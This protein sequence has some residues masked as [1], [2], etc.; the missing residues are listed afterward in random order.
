M[1]E[2]VKKYYNDI[3]VHELNRLNNHYSII[4]Y[5]STMYLIDKYMKK[6]T[7]I[8]DIGSGPGR[9][10]V[11]LLKKQYKISL[12]DISDKS[13]DLAKQ[14]I[15][16]ENYKAENYYAMS[17]LELDKFEDDTFDN[18][19][20]LGPMYHLH[21]KLDRL[22][23]LK[24]AK[25]IVKKDGIIIISYINSYGIIRSS[26]F[27]FPEAYTDDK[28][29][30]QSLKGDLQLSSEESFTEAY[31]TKPLLAG[32]EIEEAG[33]KILS[34]AG[35]ESFLSGLHLEL[36]RLYDE[37]DQTIYNNYIRIAS[38][39]CEM[40]HYK[41]TTEHTLFVCKVCKWCVKFLLI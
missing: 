25:R 14:I 5:K 27:E 24:N 35:A 39:N 15:E 6:N 7:H 9:Y 37:E 8:F 22:E 28:S 23:V 21:S 29:F 19:L 2:I 3:S 1:S 31:F 41:D 17:A 32:K 38:E 40:E 13:I 26:L 11:D 18:A 36:K 4:E 16:K 12:L 34:Y 30:N 33:L 20:I 10:S